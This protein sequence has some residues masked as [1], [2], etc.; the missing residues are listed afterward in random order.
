MVTESHSHED[1]KVVHRAPDILDGRA[2]LR[3]VELGSR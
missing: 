1:M 3:G 2:S